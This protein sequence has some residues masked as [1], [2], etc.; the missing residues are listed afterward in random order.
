MKKI[1]VE[2]RNMAYRDIRNKYGESVSHAIETYASYVELRKVSLEE[3]KE[4]II[5]N[6]KIKEYDIDKVVSQALRYI[7]AEHFILAH[8]MVV[9][10]WI[11]NDYLDLINRI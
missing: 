9:D 7:V 8:K 1:M 11:F 10:D 6:I 5:S 3:I 2:E 4:I